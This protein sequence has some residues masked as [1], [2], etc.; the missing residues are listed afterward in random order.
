MVSR[1]ITCLGSERADKGLEWRGHLCTNL[2]QSELSRVCSCCGPWG[3]DEDMLITVRGAEGK[4]TTSRVVDPSLKPSYRQVAHYRSL[5]VRD[6]YLQGV[7]SQEEN[8]M[9]VVNIS[10]LSM[11]RNILRGA[12]NRECTE[13]RSR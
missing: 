2:C 3:R 11:P 6:S 1:C 9:F 4:W 12:E 5:F 10:D 8:M 13:R 7:Y